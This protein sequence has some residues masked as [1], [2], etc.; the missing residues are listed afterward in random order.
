MG[1]IWTAKTIAE[2]LNFSELWFLN[3]RNVSPTNYVLE[4]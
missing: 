4:I 2:S 3:L 1:L